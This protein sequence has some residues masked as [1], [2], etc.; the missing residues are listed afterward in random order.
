MKSRTKLHVIALAVA[1]G[2]GAGTVFGAIPA[3]ERDALIALYN[4]AGGPGWNDSNNWLD[5]PGSEC[6]WTGVGCDPGENNVTALFLGGQNMVGFIPP[7]MEDLTE[8]D[9]LALENNQ[10][11]EGGIPSELG[12]LSMLT[13]LDLNN[14]QLGGSIPTELADLSNL[15][16]LGLAE[17]RLTGPIPPEFGSL[18]SLQALYLDRNRLSGPIPVELGNLGILID[19][20]LWGNQLTGPIPPE[21]GD[22]SQLLNMS[23]DN[24]RLNGPIPVELADLNLLQWLNLS[25]NELT[26]E[27]PPQLSTLPDLWWLGLNHNHLSGQIPTEFANFQNLRELHLSENNLT[28]PIPPGLADIP[29]LEW[30]FFGWNRFSGEIPSELGTA[31]GLIG[32]FLEN[33]LLSGSIPSQLGGLTGLEE[34]NLSG[35]FLSGPIPAAIGGMNSLRNLDLS[36]NSLEGP[37]PTQIGDLAA[38]EYLHLSANKIVG[39]VPSQITNLGGLQDDQSRIDFNG[40]RTADPGVEAFMNVKFGG[41]WRDTQTVPPEGLAEGFVTGIATRLTWSPIAYQWNEGGYSV[42]VALDIGGPYDTISRTLGKQMSDWVLFDLTPSTTYYVKLSTTT[43]PHPENQNTVVSDLTEPLTITTTA[44]PS[45]WYAAT[46]GVP[47][48]DCATPGTPCPTIQE[49]IQRAGQGEQIL[50]APGAYSEL[51]DIGINVKIAGDD[52]ATTV[53]DG[54]GAGPVVWIS[55]GRHARMSGLK[56]TNGAFDAGGCVHQVNNSVFEFSDGIIA[57]CQAFGPGGGLFTENDAGARIERVEMSNNTAGDRGG[58]VYATGGTHVE[59]IDSTISGNS[60]QWGGGLFFESHSIVTRT[61]VDGNTAEGFGGGGIANQGMMGIADSAV[62]NNSAAHG[63]GVA[64]LVGANLDV[65]NSTISG[66][67]GGGLFNGQSA[68][69]VVESCTVAENIAPST[70]HSGLMNWNELFLHNT[71]VA[72]NTPFNCANPVT[73]YGY[74]LEDDSTCGLEGLGDVSDADP[75][76]G[77]LA[78]NGGP[79]L[80]H[81]L[82]LDSPAIDAGDPLDYPPTD[83]R[84]YDRP[85]DGISAPDIGAYENTDNVFT[86]GFESG[87]LTRWS[88]DG[89]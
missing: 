58:A 36:R 59:I 83:Q 29:N 65:G 31:S 2:L 49:A 60:A 23:I 34:L 46:T 41:G 73:S 7:E 12:S 13:W 89:P 62:T 42:H 3:T 24:N 66:N 6:T 35:N 27:I 80:T 74:N 15:S 87:D 40:L 4:A 45:T 86:D 21:L 5:P 51:L 20:H 30:L 56:I 9:A 84:G 61:T 77:P 1:L 28:G 43:E 44:D 16:F 39:E 33:N 50:V 47:G 88:A 11:L 85:S 25:F 71:I 55:W 8:L 70:E 22:L 10:G 79:T 69:M 38:L 72:G 54:N 19:L 48:N 32:I 64:N 81:A 78:D 17:N 63:G 37:I 57:D 67:T 82:P 14:C 75:M 53:I 52:A 26:G 76:L 68:R 18:S